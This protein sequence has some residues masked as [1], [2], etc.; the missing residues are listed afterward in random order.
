MDHRDCIEGPSLERRRLL[1]KRMEMVASLMYQ[2]NEGDN[3][4]QESQSDKKSKRVHNCSGIITLNWL[5]HLVT[6][7]HRMFT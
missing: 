7:L 3:Q 2:L 6:V 1:E 4:K 5:G